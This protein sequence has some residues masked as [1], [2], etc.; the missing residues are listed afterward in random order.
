VHGTY[1]FL[2]RLRDR[3]TL[4]SFFLRDSFFP[5]TTFH[6][7]GQ[8]GWIISLFSYSPPPRSTS[9][10]FPESSPPPKITKKTLF[11]LSFHRSPLLK[12]NLCRFPHPPPPFRSLNLTLRPLAPT[13]TAKAAP[14]LFRLS[15]MLRTLTLK[16]PG[17]TYSSHSQNPCFFPH[18]LPRTTS[19][20]IPPPCAA[21]PPLPFFFLFPSFPPPG[22]QGSSPTYS[23]K[24]P[25]LGGPS[26][27]DRVFPF[28]FTS[29]VKLRNVPHGG[30]GTWCI[31]KFPFLAHLPKKT[32]ADESLPLAPNIQNL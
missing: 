27:G 28:C 23:K 7:E 9:P 19:R 32:L 1:G 31:V 8:E 15:A 22:N 10:P 13:R 3:W 6:S 18:L 16:S 2:S 20:P 5:W 26:P 17:R 24:A 30:T 12:G 14:P 29:Q 4:F 21:C 11:A 25:F